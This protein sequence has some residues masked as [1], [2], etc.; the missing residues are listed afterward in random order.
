MSEQANQG[1]KRTHGSPIV[2]GTN[3]KRS[4]VQHTELMDMPPEILER[5]F[6]WVESPQSLIIALQGMQD[7]N[8][9][10]EY[11]MHRHRCFVYAHRMQRREGPREPMIRAALMVLQ[12]ATDHFNQCGYESHF[13]CNL[14]SFHVRMSESTSN[15]IH[16]HLRKFISEFLLSVEKPLGSHEG[17][18]LADS[19]MGAQQRRFLLM[20][21][22][23]NLLRQFRSF[24]IMSSAMRL[25]QWH[26]KIEVQSIFLRVGFQRVTL[27]GLEHHI[28]ILG[29]I[30]EMLLHDQLNDPFYSFKT[31][32][33]FT[34]GYGLNVS[35]KLTSSMVFNFSILAPQSTLL[36]LQKAVAGE[37][38]PLHV[39]HM[40][41]T[42]A[43]NVRLVMTSKSKYQAFS[44]T[45]T[46]S[47]LLAA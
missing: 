18:A 42:S 13:V 2:G 25:M 35:K 38:D 39:A 46:I 31:V 36:L 20:L 19:K 7:T 1:R 21:T 16:I 12:A 3:A 45:D 8:Q 24:T 32:D 27:R 30:A 44:A 40:T 4:R 6:S 33:Q 17:S 10:T 26:L 41:A 29:L 34:Y 47:L 28:H 15:T 43:F 5:I 37:F 22:L 9:Y 11:M 23:I 14:A